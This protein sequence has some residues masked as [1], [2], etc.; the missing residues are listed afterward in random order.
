MRPLKFRFDLSAEDAIEEELG[1]PLMEALDSIGSDKNTLRVIAK[2]GL[3]VADA[4][5]Y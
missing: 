2:R 3:F 5:T 4:Q 1:R